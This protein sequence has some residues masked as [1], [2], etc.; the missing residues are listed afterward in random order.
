MISKKL[1]T[2]FILFALLIFPLFARAQ[3]LPFNGKAPDSLIQIVINSVKQSLE[4]SLEL[5]QKIWKEYLVEFV[6]PIIDFLE[7]EIE[8]R[9]SIFGEELKKEIDELKDSFLDLLKFLKNRGIS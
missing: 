2:A 1:I 3:G 5:W 8:Y 6:N 4:E 9:K 7:K